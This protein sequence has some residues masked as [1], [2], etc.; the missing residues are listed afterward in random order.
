MHNWLFYLNYTQPLNI[1]FKWIST[2]DLKIQSLDSHTT[3]CWHKQFDIIK[4]AINQSCVN[5]FPQDQMPRQAT[6]LFLSYHQIYA[7][8]VLK[9]NQNVAQRMCDLQIKLLKMLI[10]FKFTHPLWKTYGI[11]S[12]RGVWI[13]NGIAQ[14]ASPNVF[15][16]I[17]LDWLCHRFYSRMIKKHNLVAWC[18]IWSWG[19]CHAIGWWHGQGHH[20]ILI[21]GGTGA[22]PLGG[23]SPPEA[24]AFLAF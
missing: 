21:C 1:N 24:P 6:K 5:L 15:D 4:H 16:L 17:S 10:H 2:L 20:F 3:G 23:V 18:G 9:L 13:S 12:T 19:N 8:R 11:S 22:E 14:F 7:L